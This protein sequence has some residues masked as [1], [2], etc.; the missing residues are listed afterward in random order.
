[1]AE[2]PT[3]PLDD[4]QVEKLVRFDEA[5]RL[6]KEPA[7]DPEIEP[8]QEF[9]RRLQSIWKRGAQR[10]GPYVIVGNLGQG[11]IGPAYLVEHSKSRERFVLKT[12]WPDLNANLMVQK[13]V[14]MAA[15]R[16]AST[17]AIDTAGQV[18]YVVSEYNPGPSLAQWRLRNPQPLAWPV[19]VST[20]AKLADSL[21]VAHGK[22]IVHGNF[23]PTN[24]FLPAEGNITPANLHETTIRIAEFGFATAVL[25]AR[26][27]AYG[28]LPWPMPH[29][30]APEQLSHRRS[31]TEPASDIYALGV[32]LYEL[33]TGRAPVAGM[34][35]DEVYRALRDGTPPP[36]SRHRADLPPELDALVLKCLDKK[37]AERPK[38]ARHFAAALRV[39][40]QEK[41]RPAWWKQWFGWK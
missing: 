28:G 29:Y 41:P 7:A 26:L 16:N 17:K 3:D 18:T 14:I 8:T 39:L 13:I 10:I 35:R 23:K 9:L 30:L 34:T 37:P 19:A 32:L 2:L 33:L 12:L 15:Q 1:M 20:V 31:K 6:G 27:P 21:E 22:N 40:T 36:P 38:S 11:S 5:L 24:L 25:R 4:A